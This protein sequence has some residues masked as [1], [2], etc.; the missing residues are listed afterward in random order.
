MS[1]V[2]NPQDIFQY[3]ESCLA[4]LADD[5]R[6]IRF[7]VE[8][9]GTR[10]DHFAEEI[11]A[12]I[13]DLNGWLNRLQRHSGS[14]SYL[15][16]LGRPHAWQQFSRL[17]TDLQ[18]AINIYREMY[19]SKRQFVNNVLN[20]QQTWVQPVQQ[21]VQANLEASNKVFKQWNAFFTRS[22]ATCGYSLGDLYHKLEICPSC[23]MLL[24]R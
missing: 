22:C 6:Q 23:G 12:L 9:F 4:G 7:R 24:R 10:P 15:Y 3:E 13:S 16:R 8:N 14:A 19:Q 2:P 11:A 21:T 20:T 5:E 17:I 18:Q 1:A